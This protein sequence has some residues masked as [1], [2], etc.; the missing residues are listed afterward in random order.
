VFVGGVTVQ[1][2]TLHNQDEVHRK[3]VRA[4]D[5]VVVRRAGDVIPEVVRV[6]LDKRPAQT[7]IFNMPDKCPICQSKVERLE[8]EAVTRCTAGLFC[9]AQRKQAI[10]HFASRRA[11]DIEGL[12]EKLVDQLVEHGVL[13]TPA[14][15]YA[16]SVQT[17]ANLERMGKKS[18]ANLVQAI[19]NSRDTTLPRFIYALGIRNVGETTARDLAAEFGDIHTLMAAD[20]QTLQQAPDV[21]PVVAQSIAH[22]F[23]EPH[24]CE[25]VNKLIAAGVRW[26]APVMRRSAGGLAGKTFV[27]TG[28]L[29]GL[30]R[31]QAAE[32]IQA[33]GGKVTGS[34]SKKTDYV[35]VGADPGSKYDKARELNIP[36]L[37]EEGLLHLLSDSR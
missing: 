34:V 11:M 12:G 32:R 10:L 13:K 7:S 31:E 15:I 4:G 29:P 9:P 28:T 16:L 14:D 5:S 8:G 22:F 26:K 27:L 6:L 21:G 24:N 18:A 2:A 3:D 30:S 37:D 36:V 20:E 1:N 19:D 23:R 33:A 17:L 25:V 35:V